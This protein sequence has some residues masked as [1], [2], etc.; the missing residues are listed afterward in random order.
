MYTSLGKWIYFV[1]CNLVIK[2]KLS[3]LTLA[4]KE[5]RVSHDSFSSGK[6]VRKQALISHSPSYLAACL[7]ARS[8]HL[9]HDA[10]RQNHHPR[11]SGTLLAWWRSNVGSGD[12]GWRGG[13]SSVTLNLVEGVDK[14]NTP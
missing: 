4:L 6:S 10:V 7:S 3:A 8:S 1:L 11:A 2:N 5:C 14:L 12:L 13:G 9:S